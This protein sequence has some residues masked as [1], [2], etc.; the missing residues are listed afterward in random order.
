LVHPWQMETSAPALRV[1]IVDSERLLRWALHQVLGGAGW[2]TFDAGTAQA[3]I[4]IVSAEPSIDAVVVDCN[5]PDCPDLSLLEALTKLAPDAVIVVMSD[6]VDVRGV[7]ARVAP[8]GVRHVLAKPFDLTALPAL[9][10]GAV[11]ERRRP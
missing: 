5:L 10:V 1:L 3:A 2:M 8:Y 9:I 4:G 7:T 11:A 6:L